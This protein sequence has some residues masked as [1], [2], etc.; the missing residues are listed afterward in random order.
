[1]LK[2]KCLT[3]PKHKK[4]LL[5]SMRKK[6]NKKSKKNKKMLNYLPLNK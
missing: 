4:Y 3:N 1:M 6:E 5:K 2:L